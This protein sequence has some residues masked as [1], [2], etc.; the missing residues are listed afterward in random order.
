MYTVTNTYH[1][2]LIPYM[3]ETKEAML[4]EIDRLTEWVQEMEEMLTTDGT[5]PDFMR[6]TYHRQFT[7]GLD[8]LADLN[9]R[10]KA[11]GWIS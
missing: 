5:V 2:R 7:Q 8:H 4:A 10:A 1:E 11:Q 9:T 6:V 3:P